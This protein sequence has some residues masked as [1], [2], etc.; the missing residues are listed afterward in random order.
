MLTSSVE[1]VQ[2]G[3][4]IVQ[5]NVL[6]PTPKLVTAVVGDEELSIVPLPLT[7][8]HLPVPTT[9]L[10]PNSESLFAFAHK[11]LSVPAL[12]T[13]GTSLTFIVIS[14]V[15]LA[16]APPFIVQRNTLAPIVSP[17]TPDPGDKGEVTVPPPLITLQLPVPDVGVFPVIFAVV[18]LQSD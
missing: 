5:R 14:S 15:K 1:A 6:T 13:V 7:S 11:V 8:V 2:G 17:V 18:K 10:F 3:L 16:Q 4:L 12:A 9:G